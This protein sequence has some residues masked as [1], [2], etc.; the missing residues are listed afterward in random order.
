M[1]TPLQRLEGIT[2]WV[3]EDP[4]G[5]YDFINTQVRKEWE[6]DV[7]REGRETKVDVW[8]ATLPKRRWQLEKVQTEHVKLDQNIMNFLDSQRGYSVAENLAKR[9]R[10]L[11]GAIQSFGIVIWPII[12]RKESM[13]IVDGYCR[14]SV[15]KE[16][17]IRN[18]YAYVGSL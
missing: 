1:K 8:L 7:R 18:L 12:I 6:E 10:E 13:Q 4:D 2:Y 11:H 5:I 14:Y 16:M 17:G 9:I 3:I 15:L